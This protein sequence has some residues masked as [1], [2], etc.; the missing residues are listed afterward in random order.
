R[1]EC[2]V[3]LPFGMLGRCCSQLVEHESELRV[4]RLLAP[5]RAVV[6][7][8]SDALGLRHEVLAA[9]LRNCIDECDDALLRRAIVPR[10]QCLGANSSTRDHESHE[11]R[12]PRRW[13][14][15]RLL[16]S[17]SC[18]DMTSLKPRCDI[19]LYGSLPRRALG[20]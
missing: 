20:R 16:A 4:D 19:G 10:R 12:E 9:L 17:Q 1:V 14:A 11:A 6:V 13:R 8:D 2:G 3:A 18:C 5:Q 15:H 7:E